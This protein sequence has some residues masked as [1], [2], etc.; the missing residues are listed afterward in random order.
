M[1]KSS[2]V[3]LFLC[4]PIAEVNKRR[5]EA[6]LARKDEIEQRFGEPLLWEFKENRKQQYLRSCCPFGGLEEDSKWESIHK[7]LIDRLVRLENA[8]RDIIRYIE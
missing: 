1:E 8:L 6:L 3:E 4:A 7:D 5:F 2:R